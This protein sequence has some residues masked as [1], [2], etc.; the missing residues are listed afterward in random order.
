MIRSDKMTVFCTTLAILALSCVAQAQGPSPQDAIIGKPK[1]ITCT[2]TVIDEQDRPIAGARVSMYERGPGQAERSVDTRLKGKVATKADGKFTFSTAINSD[3]YSHYLVAE[4]EGFAFGWTAW[5]T[6]R[7]EAKEPEIR[8]G[9][10]TELAGLI[11]DENDRP[12]P[13]AQVGVCWLATGKRL[14]ANDV[15]PELLT[16]ETDQAGRF[17]FTNLPSKAKVEFLVRKTGY[18]NAY[19]Y[20]ISRDM[21][22]TIGQTDIKLALVKEAMIEGVV[23]E[24]DS[25]R[26]VPGVR[27][28]ILREGNRSIAGQSPAKTKEDGTFNLNALAAGNYVVQI[29]R[30]R[31]GS[32]EWVAEPAK[33]KLEAGHVR[34]D[35]RIEAC[36]GGMLEVRI[37]DAQS[38]QPLEK[39][40]V[41]VSN[42][43]NQQIHGGSDKN[44][45]ARVRLM[46]GEWRVTYLANPGY[47]TQMQRGNTITVED[48]KT[49]RVE[50]QLAA[51]P[52]ITG[53][54][55]DEDNRPVK[56]AMVN[57]HPIGSRY[58]VTTDAEGKFEVS[59]SSQMPMPSW[60]GTT[61]WLMARHEGRNLAAIDE[62]VTKDT[63]VC[64]IELKPG[65]IIIGKV[66]DPDGTGIPGANLMVTLKGPKW[67]LARLKSDSSRT[68]GNGEF[69]IRAVPSG[70]SC[71]IKAEA[72]RYGS[73]R[74][75]F[76]SDAA[77]DQR[78]ALE[79]LTLPVA[80][81]SVS[82]VVV[83][84][85]G[86]PIPKATISFSNARGQPERL[87]TQT[88]SEGRFN[89]DGVCEGQ[90]Y[91][92]VS[93]VYDG[94]RL[95]ATAIANGGATGL[96]D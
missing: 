55:R 78:L 72:E 73:I 56:G 24:E 79:P 58:D 52:K 96:K 42:G 47:K 9:Q 40:R 57:I 69:E 16:T 51:P 38:E 1:Q 34:K 60:Y 20:T 74:A 95:S 94:K 8:L 43:R 67:P 35:L 2:G 39:A 15:V 89:L 4:K 93:T 41:N 66:A 85:Q 86:H 84:T 88:D 75:E 11:V 30:M 37:T 27:V 81:L 14:L 3:S 90:L 10:Q 5:D 31:D 44:G 26:P 49:V 62:N 80:N 22:Y 59:W 68:D 33:V 28:S 92:R 6:Q 65:V 64:D 82:G 32:A 91:L 71:S 23:V 50:R 12:I 29:L 21:K 61:L 17:A 87:A 19:T 13:Q 54:V 18:A 77:K 25:A 53:I 48:G 83:D 45:I 7:D 76:H 70:H 46:P 63:R 36:K